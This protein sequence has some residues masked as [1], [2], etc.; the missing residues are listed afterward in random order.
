MVGTREGSE[1][2]A[3]YENQISDLSVCDRWPPTAAAQSTPGP[4]PLFRERAERPV[5]AYGYVG[6]D[7]RGLLYV[8][9]NLMM[10]DRIFG[11]PDE[12]DGHAAISIYRTRAARGPPGAS[13]NCDHQV[14]RVIEPSLQI[15]TS[16]HG[17]AGRA[18]ES[19]SSM[20]RIP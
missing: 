1:G 12:S 2:A 16:T 20:Q 4:E 10:W 7:E 11:E 9:E 17:E 5:G 8:L 13:S 19:R 14:D 18:R 6:N 15:K 3:G